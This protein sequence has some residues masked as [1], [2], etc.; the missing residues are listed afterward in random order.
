M[1]HSS[2][3]RQ[4]RIGCLLICLHACAASAQQVVLAEAGSGQAVSS[5]TTNGAPA[6]GIQVGPSDK[7]L[8]PDSA[9]ARSPAVEPA[10][11]GFLADA[12]LGL[13][14]RNYNENI[15]IKNSRSRHGWVQSG[16][17]VF[18]S[19]FTPGPVGFGIDVGAYG[20]VKLDGGHGTR[21]MVYLPRAGT[22][23]NKKAWAYLG[24]YDVK[25][26]IAGIIVKYGLQ[27]Q[28]NPYLEPYDMRALP[29]TWRGVSAEGP[30]FAGM[31]FKAGS[32]DAMNARGADY[33]Q[34]L[35]TSY[36]GT[37]F[38]RLSFAGVDWNIVNNGV[39]SLYTSKARDL[40]NQTYASASQSFGTPKSMKWTVRADGYLTRDVGAQLEGPIDNKA[41]S[42]SLSLQRSASTILFGFQQIRGD[43]FFDDLQETSGIYLSNAMGVDYNAP[44]ERSLQLRYT[45][46]GNVGGVPG[47]RFP[48]WFVSG[49]GVDGSVEAARNGSA[50]A[51]LH[52]LYWMYGNPI[53]GGHHEFGMKPSYTF[54]AGILKNTTA[55]LVVVNHRVN[56]FYPSK[57]FNDLR[58]GIETPIRIF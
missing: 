41:Y 35:T 30:L 12:K 24:E 4:V 3:V 36:G 9:A 50:S 2:R 45:F 26:R 7:A 25:L 31:S 33:L 5:G 32:F 23:E 17:L 57:S 49:R 14:L 21:N 43:Q 15:Q 10:T 51:P 27:P 54:Q 52:D 38:K 42:I 44:H 53:S 22:N 58:W 1:A 46:D 40:W 28:S 19:G 56:S 20:A 37:T 34:D 8:Q 48:V 39:L 13:F 6:A 55:F 11:G 47:F 18:E 29:P 16:R